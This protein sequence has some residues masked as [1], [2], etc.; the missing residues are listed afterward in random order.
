M[1]K[2]FENQAE[3]EAFLKESKEW[4]YQWKISQNKEQLY[5]ISVPIPKLVLQKQNDDYFWKQKH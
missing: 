3:A 5:A 2:N 1:I 4:I